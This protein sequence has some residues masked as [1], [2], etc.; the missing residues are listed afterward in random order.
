MKIT[1]LTTL[2]ESSPLV[3]A[4]MST[5]H[6]ER[7]VVKCET[8]ESLSGE[9][10]LMINWPKIL[11]KDFIDRQQIVLNVHNSLLPRY[12]GRH[13]FTWA[14]LNGE[15][16]LGFSLHVVTPEIDAGDVLGNISFFLGDNEDVVSAFRRGEETLISWL[17]GV[18]DAWVRGELLSVPQDAS[19]AT[20]FR[21]RND[22][23]N[24]L[25]SFND[26]ILVRNLVRAVAPPY[27]AGAKCLG[28]NG[29]TLRISSAEFAG[30]LS[31]DIP[32]GAILERKGKVL[33]VACGGSMLRLTITSG[34]AVGGM[35]IGRSRTDSL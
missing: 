26:A 1:L 23:D 15:R 22:E 19:Q 9:N 29:D 31:A 21:K 34:E 4:L 8:A 6:I 11:R 5:G 10:V 18:L 30:N 33:T 35:L 32:S 25:P 24:W 28:A 3:L 17:P 16:E 2:D 27:T 14:I 12:R 20:Y 13:A 7:L